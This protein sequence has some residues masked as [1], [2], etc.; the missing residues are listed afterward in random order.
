MPF[1]R[2]EKYASA[3]EQKKMLLAGTSVNG[4]VVVCPPHVPMSAHSRDEEIVIIAI[5]ATNSMALLRRMLSFVFMVSIRERQEATLLICGFLLADSEAG[6][7]VCVGK[8]DP[9]VQPITAH[10]IRTCA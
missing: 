3:I 5:A 8:G 9:E 4:R 7:L 1:V 2:A 10:T 6:Q